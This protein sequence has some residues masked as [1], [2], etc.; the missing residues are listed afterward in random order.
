MTTL[1]TLNLDMVNLSSVVPLTLANLTSLRS[2]SLSSCGLHGKFPSSIF[3][4]PNLETLG[5]SQNNNLKGTLPDFLSSTLRSLDVSWTSFSGSIPP[6]IG[7]LG[8]LD[9]IH[10]Q[11]CNFMGALPASLGNLTNLKI[12]Q[13]DENMFTGEIPP[14]FANLTQL[15]A[16]DPSNNNIT[17]GPQVFSWLPKR[18]GLINVGF[19]RTNMHGTIPSCVANL[20]EL[21]VLGFHYNHLSGPIP[22][23]LANLTHLRALDLE[24]NPL[25]QGPLP[26]EFSSLADLQVLTVGSNYMFVDFE[27]IFRMKNLQ[28]MVFS[29][30]SIK[31]PSNVNASATKP[32]F[33]ILK[34]NSCNLTEFPQFLKDQDKLEELHLLD[35]KITGRIPLWLLNNNIDTLRVLALS[36]NAITGFERPQVWF[37][38]SGL[39]AVFLDNNLLEGSLIFPSATIKVYIA[40]TNKLDGDL[41]RYIC[42][43]TSLRYLDISNNNISGELPQCMGDLGGSLVALN[44]RGNQFHGVIPATYTKSCKLKLINLSEN[45]FRGRLPRSLANCK[46]LEVLDVGRN[47]IHD[48]FPSWLRSVPMLHILVLRCNRFHGPVK[49][50]AFDVEFTKLRIMDLSHNFH[51]GLLPLDYIQKWNTMKGTDGPGPS[52]T[53]IAISDL[54]DWKGLAKSRPIPQGN[55]FNTFESSAFEGNPGLCG[56]PLPKSCENHVDELAPLPPTLS[57]EGDDEHS[58]FD[59]VE[60]IIISL[61]CGSGFIVG[62]VAGKFFTDWKHHWFLKTFGA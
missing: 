26:H 41:P 15:I 53:V 16:F 20:T 46:Q 2:I 49:S 58:Y 14:S 55:Q 21:R 23:W 13:L 18:R 27:I 38:R 45:Q 1:E 60:W 8:S 48:T 44:L 31:F 29:H 35:N 42:D 22:S 62:F 51:V 37:Q 50:P 59:T 47:H 32:K 12:L 33:Q 61:G 4:L 7:N 24:G 17:I 25:M 10:L 52:E 30:A 6:S 36:H 11:G 34:L 40:S 54:N 19:G 57:S 43:M 56:N 39:T 5:V 28:A 9:T 3:H